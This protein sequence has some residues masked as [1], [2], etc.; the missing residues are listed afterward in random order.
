M[1]TCSQQ[2][3]GKIKWFDAKK[4]YGFITQ[5]EGPDVF[6]HASALRFGFKP[7]QGD[8][9]EFEIEQGQRGPKAAHVRLN[10]T[11]AG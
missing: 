5:A 11:A 3:T 4:G 6:L 1:N 2:V 10:E 8:A 9:V 7:A